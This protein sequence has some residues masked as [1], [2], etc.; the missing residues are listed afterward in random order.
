VAREAELG[1]LSSDGGSC[2]Y[3]LSFFVHWR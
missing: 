3:V 2:V 1:V